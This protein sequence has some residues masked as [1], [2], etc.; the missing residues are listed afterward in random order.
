MFKISV[1]D[2]KSQRRLVLEGTLVRPWTTDVEHAW[3]SAREQSQ[4]RKLVIDLIN[5]TLISGDGQGTLLKLMKEGARFA[6]EGVL[7]K[8]VLKQL[9]RRCRCLP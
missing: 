8:H 4:G 5:V 2:T 7:M 6:C 3:N 1:I 9:A